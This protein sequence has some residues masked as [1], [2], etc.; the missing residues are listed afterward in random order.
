MLAQRTETP[1]L[2][3]AAAAAALPIIRHLSHR[4]D[5]IESAAWR[6]STA[7]ATSSSRGSS[8]TSC[9]SIAR[10]PR[11]RRSG[12]AEADP[13]RRSRRPRRRREAVDPRVPRVRRVGPAR[14]AAGARHPRAVAGRLRSRRGDG[15]PHPA[16]RARGARRRR[17]S[18]A[19]VEPLLLPDW[20]L[21]ASVEEEYNAVYLQTAASGDL[22]LF[23]KGA[24]ALPTAT[25]VLG[26]LI[27][28]AQDNSVQWPEPRADRA[29]AAAA[30]PPLPA[31]HRRAASRARAPRRQPRAPRRA[32]RAEPRRARRAARHAPR[33]PDLAVRR[34]ADRAGRRPA[35]RARPRRA[36]AVAR[37]RRS[38][39]VPRS[40]SVPAERPPRATWPR[41]RASSTTR[42]R[43]TRRGCTPSAR[44]IQRDLGGSAR[45][46]SRGRKARPRSCSRGDG[47]WSELPHLY[48]RYGT[49]GTARAD[50]AR[51]ARSSTRRCA[52]VTDCGMQAV[53]LVA[54]ALLAA[55]RARGRDAAGLQQDARRS[56]SAS[57]KRVGATLTLVD[58][59]DHAALA[60]ALTPDDARSCSPRRSRTRSAARRTSRRSPRSSRRVPGAR[61]VID[62]TIATP[63]A[64]RTPLLDARRRRRRR[65][66]DQGARRPGPRAR[67]L[68]RDRR[69]ASSR[70]QIMDLVAMRGGILDDDR[71]RRGRREPRRRR[72]R[73]TRGAARPPRASPRSSRAHPRVERVF[74]PSPARSPRRRRDRARLRAHRLA[75]RVPRRATPTRPRT[76]RSPTARR[77]PACRATRCRSTA[78]PRR[79]TTT[80]RCREYFTPP[81]V[82]ARLGI[83]R[84]IRLG[85]GLEDAD[86][87]I[88]C[89]NWTLHHG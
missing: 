28:L 3:E 32:H 62:S 18:T 27:D 15:L 66:P 60:A 82:V 29:R 50:R 71:A 35:A 4:A 7:R 16:D 1:L 14:R 2:C 55:R 24:G 36:D 42:R 12:F 79:S 13:S 48:A 74:H 86:D 45:R 75:A 72:A 8:R 26:D 69:R 22:S 65:Q 11:R 43:A 77:R 19:A 21:L 57:A 85:V 84:L 6:S 63:W 40:A 51:C 31:R 5:E 70:N 59:G 25:A 87:L 30:A 80:G 58:D 61:L 38:D 52:L 47:A 44:T 83:D 78:S 39:V 46:S 76:A 9:R 73:I 20:H 81:E 23:G 41:R 34:R 10:S 56:S 37:S 67:R 33:L 53:A 88:A 89:L 64:L 68:H 17:R 49:P 54:D